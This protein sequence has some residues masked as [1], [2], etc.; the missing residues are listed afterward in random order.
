MRSRKDHASCHESSRACRC[1]APRNTTDKLA[2]LRV[3]ATGEQ[4]RRG[5]PKGVKAEA[6]LAGGSR[7]I[8][9]LDDV[10]RNERLPPPD[11]LQR[12]VVALTSRGQIPGRLL[13]LRG[14][15]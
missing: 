3:A 15:Q 5:N 6:K 13:S 2:K 8:R 10:Y 14:D 9:S 4:R 1:A 7:T 11:P 12:C